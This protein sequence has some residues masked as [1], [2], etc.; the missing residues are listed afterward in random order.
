MTTRRWLKI[1]NHLIWTKIKDII[2]TKWLNI[3]LKKVELVS[4]KKGKRETV[5]GVYQYKGRD[6]D[7]SP[8][9]FGKSIQRIRQVIRWSKLQR[10]GTYR[11]FDKKN[12]IK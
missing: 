2:N 3:R 11:S 8:R 12:E 10:N 7:I 6:V 1:K 4:F 5:T 9:E